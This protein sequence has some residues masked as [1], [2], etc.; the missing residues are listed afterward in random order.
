MKEQKS[1]IQEKKMKYLL[2]ACLEKLLA[3]HSCLTHIID[4]K[5]LH[6]FFFFTLCFLFYKKYVNLE[7]SRHKV[8]TKHLQK[9]LYIDQF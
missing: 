2:H 1:T 5:V 6:H 3:A 7:I 8:L 4:A 9:V